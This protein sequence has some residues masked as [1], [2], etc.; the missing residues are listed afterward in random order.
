MDGPQ[1]RSFERYRKVSGNFSHSL[2]NDRK[3]RVHRMALRDHALPNG[4]ARKGMHPGSSPT[5]I[6]RYG[7]DEPAKITVAWHCLA[8]TAAE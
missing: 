4:Y 5:H 2:E 7:K 1:G 6:A 3:T 8:A